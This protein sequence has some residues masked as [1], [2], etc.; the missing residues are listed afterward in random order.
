[1]R[2]PFAKIFPK[3][4]SHSGKRK[5]LLPEIGEMGARDGEAQH[6]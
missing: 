3:I 1:M 6:V 5:I 4:R 2:E